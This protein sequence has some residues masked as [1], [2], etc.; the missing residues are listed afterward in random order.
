MI[1]G[2]LRGFEPGQLK[3]IVEAVRRGGL[4]HLE[5]TMNSPGAA[6]QIAH[7][8]VLGEGQLA[9]GAGTVTS[10]ALLDAALHAGAE[11]IVT[12]SLNPEVITACVQRKIPV[13]PGAFSPAE[14]LTA[15]ELGAAMVKIFPAEFGGAR[16]LKALRGPFP[17]IKLMPTGGVELE[18]LPKL[19]EAG[20]AGAGVGSPLFRRD[21]I[22][23]GDWPW[24][25]QQTRRYVEAWP[26]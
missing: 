2:I 23:A 22:D 10:L 25:E 18:S 8:R 20:A 24:L 14:I 16:Y 26:A 3:G 9:I 4:R 11:F 13:Y 1:V 12:P 19:I 15:W 6:E 17:H 7:A 21:R 5:I